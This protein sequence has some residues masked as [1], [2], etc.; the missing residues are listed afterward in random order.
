MTMFHEQALVR[1]RRAGMT[2]LGALV[3]CL[4]AFGATPARAAFPGQ[5]GRIA[6]SA[7]SDFLEFD[8]F[9][10]NPDGSALTNLTNSGFDD[11]GPAFSPDGSR[12]AFASDRDGDSEIYVMDADGTGVARVTDNAARDFDPAFSADGSQIAFVSDRDGNDEI[13]AVATDGSG[14]TRLTTSPAAEADPA[15]SA[16]GA[17]LAFSSDRDG[18]RD[19]YVAAADGTGPV[20]LTTDPAPDYQPNFSPDGSRIAFTSQRGD[21]VAHV[22]VMAADGTAPIQLTSS[23]TSSDHDPSFSPDG[24][25]VAFASDFRCPSGYGCGQILGGSICVTAADGSG[26]LTVVAAGAPLAKSPDWAVATGSGTP[27]DPPPDAT[28]TDTTPPD[29]AITA[30]P[31]GPINSATPSFAFTATDDRTA[32]AELQYSI[33]LDQGAWT[34]Y[35]ASTTA[36]LATV[37]GAHTFYVR[38]RDAAGNEDPSPAE[39]SFSVDTVAPTGTVT[40]QAGA[41]QTRTQTVTLTLGASDPAPASGVSHVRIS[42]TASSLTSAAW[43]TFTPTRQWTLTSGAGSKTVYVQYRDAAANQ[44]AIAL[45]TI[46]YKP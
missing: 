5:N 14:A 25:E 45:D 18:D 12:I 17:Q 3:A 8:V 46:R 10:V 29:T 33:R 20:R 6:F 4:L 22:Y 11:G 32:T 16:D 41:V 34:S 7:L 24:T 19:V 42:N 38:A 28:P 26:A 39:R 43:T 37:D 9:A 40:I 44:S 15:F 35:F 21:G 30:G 13:F 27:P 36:M 2:I 23:D 1:F 31:S